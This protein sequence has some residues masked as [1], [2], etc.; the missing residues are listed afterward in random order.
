MVQAARD[1]PNKETGDTKMEYLKLFA[2][3]LFVLLSAWHSLVTASTPGKSPYA[4]APPGNPNA[5]LE[6]QP[7]DPPFGYSRR[8]CGSSVL[9]S[10]TSESAPLYKYGYVIHANTG[11]VVTDVIVYI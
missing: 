4:P 10:S 7:C 8:T 5:N 11:A 9:I 2:V 6:G 3:T 1:W